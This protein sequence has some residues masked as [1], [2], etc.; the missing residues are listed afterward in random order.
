MSK[1]INAKQVAQLLTA[2]GYE[3]NYD[4]ELKTILLSNYEFSIGPAD[5]KDELNYDLIS[6]GYNEHEE[7]EEEEESFHMA[8]IYDEEESGEFT[9]ENLTHAIIEY[10]GE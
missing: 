6:Y 3:A 2:Q 4:N 10:L 1:V 8:C 7:D 5:E 9:A